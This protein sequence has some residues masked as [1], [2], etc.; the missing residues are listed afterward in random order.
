M[1][2]HD[3]NG[4]E[5]QIVVEGERADVGGDTV[6]TGNLTTEEVWG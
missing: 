3:G 1:S 2:E 6:R 4:H 5:Q